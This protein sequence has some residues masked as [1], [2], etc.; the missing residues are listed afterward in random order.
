MQEGGELQPAV[1]LGEHGYAVAGWAATATNEKAFA[2]LLARAG[3]R[4]DPA[5][6]E[7]GVVEV[8]TE[9]GHRL[10][11]LVFHRPLVDRS[12]PVHGGDWLKPR[13]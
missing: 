6:Y 11:A 4:A 8:V 12:R 13:P 10:E 5:H 1:R 3:G 7:Q 9:R 2:A